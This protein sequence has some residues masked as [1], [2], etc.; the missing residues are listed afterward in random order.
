MDWRLPDQPHAESHDWGDTVRDS[1]SDIRSS[2]PRL[3]TRPAIIS[4]NDLPNCVS[5]DIR[6]FADNC[7]LYRTIHSQQDA[8]ILQ[9]DL[10]MLQQWEAK[11][12]MS[13]NPGKCEVLRVTNKR[14]HIIHTHYKIHG[15][16]LDTVDK[17]KYLG[18]TIQSKLNSKP[19]IHNITKK[20]N[21]VR[22]F[23]QRNLSNCPRPV[24]EQAYK[25][26]VRP[27]LE[28]ACTVWDPHTK[29]LT[30]QLEMVQRRAARFVTADYRRRHSVTVLLN[31]LQW[32]TLLQRRTHSKVTMLYRI[33]HQLVAIPAS[34]P[35]SYIILQHYKPWPP[36]AAA[37]TSLPHQLLP[38]LLLP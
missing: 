12:L 19:H 35:Y 24:K 27:I 33:H 17:T 9:E 10:N 4:L 13:L 18:V 14:K 11:W 23:L 15:M 21:S 28:Y 30:S 31:Q 38:A 2:S 25:T 5:S 3:S 6:L 37:T 34:P 36:S 29:E 32:Q 8:A 16:I 7:L 20:A 26:Y 22:A 1:S